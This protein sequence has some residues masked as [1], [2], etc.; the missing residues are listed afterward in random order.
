MELLITTRLALLPGGFTQE[1]EIDYEETFA[2]VARLLL[3][4]LLFPFMRLTNGRS[5]RWMSKMIF[6]MVNS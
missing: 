5:F 4:G 2:P 6:L 3:S 1:Y